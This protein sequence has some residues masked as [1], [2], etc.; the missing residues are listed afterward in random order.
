MIRELLCFYLLW[1]I[2]NSDYDTRK[3]VLHVASFC[4][5]YIFLFLAQHS[6]EGVRQTL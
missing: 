5:T 4:K 6:I 1:V 3:Y 2:V